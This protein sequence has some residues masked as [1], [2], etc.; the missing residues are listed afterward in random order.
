[1]ERYRLAKTHKCTSFKELV[2]V[3]P[4]IPTGQFHES[5]QGTQVL[6]HL[7]LITLFPPKGGGGGG[8]AGEEG[9]NFE[10]GSCGF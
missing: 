2:L 10:W 6:P 7:P 1:M 5:C 4:H 3:F 9:M 8:W